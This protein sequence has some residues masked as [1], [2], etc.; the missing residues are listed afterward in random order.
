MAMSDEALRSRADA[1]LSLIDSTPDTPGE[2]TDLEGTQW[3]L[4]TPRDRVNRIVD[5][6]V[7]LHSKAVDMGSYAVHVSTELRTLVYRDPYRLKYPIM[8]SAFAKIQCVLPFPREQDGSTEVPL[9]PVQK[10]VEAPTES[11]G[12]PVQI[13]G[14]TIPASDFH[15][16]PSDDLMDTWTTHLPHIINSADFSGR[17]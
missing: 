2:Y 3:E 12:V 1:L 9:K 6:V 8:F 4:N 10:N 5:Q 17:Q 13:D 14:I 16:Y 11:I 7:L 15:R